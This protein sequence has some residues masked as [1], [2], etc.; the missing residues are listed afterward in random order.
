M[1]LGTLSN[2]ATIHLPT[3]G[4][5]VKLNSK[6]DDNE[7]EMYFTVILSIQQDRHLR[8]I[9]DQEKLIECNVKGDLFSLSKS[10][11]MVEEFKNELIK[12]KNKEDLSPS[13][14]QNRSGRMKHLDKD[15]NDDDDVDHKVDDDI[16]QIN[17]RELNDALSA[18]R[19]WMQVI[20]AKDES[21]QSALQVGEPALLMVKATLP[22]KLRK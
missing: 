22:S 13:L 4:C 6:D 2:I 16:E 18:T 8:Q 17:D 14:S 7:D 21:Q 15:D 10:R 5:G 20:P 19:A 11:S 12:M 1:F 9:S 3:S